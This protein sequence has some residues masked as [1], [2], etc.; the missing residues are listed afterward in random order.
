ML[1][2]GVAYKNHAR[3][4]LA[5][6]R[7]TCNY[8]SMHI[9]DMYPTIVIALFFLYMTFL[10][11]ISGYVPGEGGSTRRKTSRLDD[12]ETR[13]N[14]QI[15]DL[16][17]RLIRQAEAYEKRLQWQHDAL[18]ERCDWKNEALEDRLQRQH[19][20]LESRFTWQSAAVERRIDHGIKLAA[21]DRS[22]RVT[23]AG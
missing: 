15:A 20:A 8:R 17:Q 3:S 9:N 12:V 6:L 4:P 13:L 7:S 1:S 16:E 19:E 5:K 11:W 23:Y 14:Q 18:A 21:L 2:A 22:H 10:I